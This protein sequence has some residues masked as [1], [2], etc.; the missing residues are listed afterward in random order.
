ML[1]AARASQWMP[2]RRYAA[3]MTHDR[4]TSTADQAYQH[5]RALIIGGTY[6][7]GQLLSEGRVGSELGLS[8]TPVREAFLRLQTEGFL[9]LYPKRGALVVPLSITAGRETVQARLLLE[10]FALDSVAARGQHALTQL[11][12]EL[13]ALSGPTP[14]AEDGLRASYDF[15]HHL[16]AAAGNKT[17]TDMYDTLWHQQSRLTATVLSTPEAVARDR[18]EHHDLATALQEHRAE[19]GRTLLQTHLVTI[20][21]RIGLDTNGV[22]LPGPAV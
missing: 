15:H 13:A 16:V 22:H 3:P 1:W 7:S 19:T 20:L 9:E 12:Q 17:V 5:V 11:G 14:I 10:T 2:G 8:R 18:H 4:S 21:R 6:R